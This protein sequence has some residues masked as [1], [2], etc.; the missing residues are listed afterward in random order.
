[1]GYLKNITC[2]ILVILLMTITYRDSISKETNETKIDQ[3]IHSGLL[4]YKLIEEKNLKPID[5]I[6]NEIKVVLST[7]IYKD[8]IIPIYDKFKINFDR[9][10]SWLKKRDSI[11]FTLESNFTHKLSFFSIDNGYFWYSSR[12]DLI[13]A[14]IESWIV[15]DIP[16]MLT[17]NKL[18]ACYWNW[19]IFID[20][21]DSLDIA[22]LSMEEKKLYEYETDS[23]FCSECERLTINNCNQYPE[24]F[25]D[26]LSKHMLIRSR[27]NSELFKT[28][29][30]H[31]LM[32]L[33]K[34]NELGISTVRK[35]NISPLPTGYTWKKFTPY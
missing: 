5:S 33:N 18:K 35:M 14:G 16:C 22:Y 9:N 20:K 3:T 10:V 11:F 4:N 28:L 23:L 29:F 26:C 32:W 13:Y 12:S 7:E 8:S 1:M 2:Y 31:N 17:T 15:G 6:L 21:F 30:Y 24:L 34:V 25:K 19:Q 27:K